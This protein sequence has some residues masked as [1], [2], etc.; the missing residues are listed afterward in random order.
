ML[1]S[2]TINILT[3]KKKNYDSEDLNK[4][5][6]FDPN[7]FKIFGQKEQKSNSTEE[8]TERERCKNY[9]DLKKLEKNFKN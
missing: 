7:Q 8:K 2:F 9:Y 5:I 3:L 4:E 1:I 6:F